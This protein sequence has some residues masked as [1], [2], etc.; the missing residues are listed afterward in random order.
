MLQHGEPDG[1]Q[2]AVGPVELG[3]LLRQGHHQVQALAHLPIK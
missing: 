1:G 3:V 2:R